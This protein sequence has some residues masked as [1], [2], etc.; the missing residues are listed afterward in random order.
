MGLVQ[1]LRSP[2]YLIAASD[3]SFGSKAAAAASGVI[4]GAGVSAHSALQTAVNEL[5]P[6][7]FTE[8]T[9]PWGGKTTLPAAW[10]HTLEGAG[11]ATNLLANAALN[12]HMLEF[13]TS[14]GNIF[15]AVFRDFRI[16][17]NGAN[18]TAGSCIYAKGAIHCAFER[19]HF[20]RPYE[21]GIWFHEIAAGNIGHHNKT[22][23]CLFDQG[24]VSAGNGRGILWQASDENW[25]QDDD[26]ES[27]GGAGSEPYAIKDWSGLGKILGAN[28]VGGKDAI[29]VQDAASTTIADFMMDGVG[30]TAIHIA[31]SGCIV[32]DGTFSGGGQA[33]A[34]THSHLVFDGTGGHN[35]HSNRHTT[36]AT[37]GR[38][39][40]FVRE[41]GVSVANLN[42]HDNRFEVNGA[43]GTG[44]VERNAQTSNR[45]RRNIGYATENAGTTAFGAAV[46]SV[47]A[48]AHGL[49]VTP[50]ARD[51]RLDY[52]ADPL[53]A[54]HI[55]VSSITS[56]TFTLNIKAAPGGAG[57][58]VAWRI[59]V[60]S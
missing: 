31:G 51:F 55:W 15:K 40:S 42:V 17:H 33:S 28:F 46:T 41:L 16:D 38:L 10:R 50:V 30:G 45:Y 13:S 22:D 14:G 12:D 3:A 25:S 39:R 11:N 57:T 7:R 37:A 48:I 19:I 32:H 9:F 26:F 43:L 18:Q 23:H 44:K 1:V 53:A 27:M 58:T 54:G 36:D 56:T 2:A 5:R 52:A 34:G 47:T 49:D 60:P 24:S 21:N 4:L 8:G 59:E 35:I 20:T 29:R 6:V